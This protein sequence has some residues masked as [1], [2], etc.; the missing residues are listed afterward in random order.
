M[1]HPLGLFLPLWGMGRSLSRRPPFGERIL[2]GAQGQPW[3]EDTQLSLGAS[4]PGLSPGAQPSRVTLLGL[5]TS[6]TSAAPQPLPSESLDPGG[7]P[8]LW[9]DVF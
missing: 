4:A 7:L 1:R 5:P 3:G 8:Q 2:R 9:V 6:L